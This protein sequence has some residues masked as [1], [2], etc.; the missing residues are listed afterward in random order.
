[1]VEIVTNCLKLLGICGRIFNIKEGFDLRCFA[2][3]D[4]SQKQLDAHI[5]KVGKKKKA[6]TTVTWH[7]IECEGSGQK[8]KANVPYTI[9]TR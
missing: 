3:V 1:M 6:K 5:K 8:S 7:C 9:S 4:M 2:C